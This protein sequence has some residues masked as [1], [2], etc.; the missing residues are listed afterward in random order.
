MLAFPIKSVREN[1]SVSERRRLDSW[2]EIAKYLRREV[3]TVIRWEQTRGLPVHRLPG[4][5][6]SRVFA[7]VD[8][9]ERWLHNGGASKSD[10]VPVPG[11]GAAPAAASQQEPSRGRWLKTVAAII[12]AGL[13]SL[14]GVWGWARASEPAAQLVALGGE[15]RALDASGRVRWTYRESLDVIEQPL[16]WSSVGDL[17]ADGSL[18]LTAALRVRRPQASQEAGQLVSFTPEGALRFRAVVDDR[19]HFRDGEYGPPW[20]GVT[21]TAYKTRTGTRIAWLVHHFTWW[22]SLLVNLNA[23]GTRAGTFV[24][25]GWIQSATPSPDGRHLFISGISNSRQSNFFAVL[26]ATHPNGHS[27][28]PPGSM[29]E[30]LDC[31]DGDPLLYIVLP[32]TDLS[33]L[34]PFP[35]AGPTVM[36]LS[37][38]TFQVHALQSAAPNPATVVYEFVPAAQGNTAE[39]QPYVLREVRFSDSFW[40]WHRQ[41]EADGRLSHSS[42]ACP[43]R[44]GLE[45]QRWTRSDGWTTQQ[46]AI[47]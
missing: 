24:N 4:G 29:T 17:N 3:R 15:L 28:E 13:A 46:M 18:E 23:D 33:R 41:L 26:D 42:D 44:R 1:Q 22:P 19:F 30:C 32:R 40:E 11:A 5:K 16:L 25:S 35:A 37:D 2:K 7:Y 45:V 12:A 14:A 31:P 27:P 10:V 21:A 6:S 38:G 34:Q 9:L 20:P 47:R 39:S 43:E 8:E 36:T